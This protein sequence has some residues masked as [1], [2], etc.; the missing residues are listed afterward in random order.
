MR[1]G[2]FSVLLLLVAS[3]A[4]GG[5]ARDA[6]PGACIAYGDDWAFMI[7]PP[8]GWSL[9]CHVEDTLGVTVALWP[10]DSSWK[11]A[12]A[13]MYVNPSGRS[14]PKESLQ[15]FVNDEIGRFRKDNPGLKVENAEG[16]KTGDAAPILVR[17]LT[18]DRFGNHE[19]IAYVE[20][21]RIFAILVL[22]A[23][24]EAA[25]NSS[26]AAFERLVGSY[27]YMDKVNGEK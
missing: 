12:T 5:Q 16:L 23:R 18:G 26:F 25:F 15:A 27:R 14:D 8:P 22:T 24:S 2:L 9:V 21:K 17:K 11:D 6:E 20:S 7:V 3:V 4:Q 10:S 19:A 13:V 1:H